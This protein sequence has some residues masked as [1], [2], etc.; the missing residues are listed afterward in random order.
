MNL[1]HINVKIFA[2]T[3]PEGLSDRMIEV[4]HRWIQEKKLPELLI[5]VADYA[6]VPMGPGILLIGHEADY[7]MDNAGDQLGL[8]YNRKDEF[9]GSN[10]DR[11]RQA[12]QAAA[13]ACQLL[14][15]EFDDGSL[16]FSRNEFE[17]SV[18]DRALAPNTPETFAA[19]KPEIE[20]FLKETLGDGE[21]SLEHNSDPRK[22]FSVTV[23]TGKP[24]ELA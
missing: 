18:N 20:A 14:E 24:F 6:H 16:K 8:R 9:S 2:E 19:C 7:N 5:D 13:K 12:F 23:K 11:L 17:V 4:F 3:A 1:Q 15:S 21:Y 10:T 22:L